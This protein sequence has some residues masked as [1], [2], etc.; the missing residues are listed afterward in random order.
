MAV[1]RVVMPKLSEQMETGKIIKWLK[2]EGD[3]IQSGDILA[4]RETDKADVEIEA[5]GSGVLRKNP[6]AGLRPEDLDEQLRRAVRHAGVLGELLGRRQQDR[7]LDELPQPNRGRRGAASRPPIPSR[8]VGPAALPLRAGMRS[9]V[10]PDVLAVH[11]RRRLQVEQRIDD[12]RDLH[13]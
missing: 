6:G 5:F 4:E 11:H 7:Q 10:D 9:A 8:T 12:L 3:R 1:T 2:Q 13:E